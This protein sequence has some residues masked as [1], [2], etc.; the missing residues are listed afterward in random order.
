MST[1]QVI[2]NNAA[3]AIG[4]L[5][6]ADS[7][8]TAADSAIGLSILQRMLDSWSNDGLLIFST[9]QETISLTAGDG[10]YT[11][12]N[13]S[14]ATR[15]VKILSGFIRYSSVDY[16]LQFPTRGEWNA[17]AY[18]S[19]QGIPEFC[20]YEPAMTGTFEFYPVPSAA[21]TAYFD[22]QRAL[23]GA[24]LALGDSLSLPTGYEDAIVENLALK[25][26]FGG[27]GVQPSPLLVQSARKGLK[28]LK[29]LNYEPNV[30]S[31]SVG[32]RYD[33]TGDV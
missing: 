13:L 15:P 9:T 28:L 5:G 33:I 11:T 3:Y 26:A 29:T 25:M 14:T 1:A 19:S 30:I 12:A 20:L 6:Q 10:T 27:F 17:I 32:R 24:A 2:I 4:V 31:S 7:A 22:V 23:T 21:M 8:L 16:P 18:K